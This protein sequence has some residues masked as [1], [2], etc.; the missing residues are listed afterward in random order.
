MILKPV[1]TRSSV[2][3]RTSLIFAAFVPTSLSC[4]SVKSFTDLTG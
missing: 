1:F 3:L 4:S 2:A